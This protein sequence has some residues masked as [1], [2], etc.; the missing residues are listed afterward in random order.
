MKWTFGLIHVFSIRILSKISEKQ[1]LTESLTFQHTVTTLSLDNRISTST[2]TSLPTSQFCY[3]ILNS[4]RNDFHQFTSTVTPRLPYHA[5][6]P[7]PKIY[8]ATT[9]LTSLLN[10]HKKYFTHA[11]Y[12]DAQIYAP[13]ASCY[14]YCYFFLKQLQKSSRRSLRGW[15][16]KQIQ[17]G[18]QA[19][20]NIR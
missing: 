6:R 13:T 20:S 17:A 15:S 7:T 4:T 12:F 16:G 3:F 9:T 11:W 19:L 14:C 1:S 18:A 8:N 10:T 5:S 2:T